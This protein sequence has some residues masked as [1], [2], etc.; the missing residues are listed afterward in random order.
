MIRI[1]SRLFAAIL[2][3]TF[4]VGAFAADAADSAAAPAGTEAT[5]TGD[6]VNVRGQASLTGEVITQINKGEKVVILAEIADA[7]AKKG[8]PAAW[9]KILLPT[10]TP[11]WIHAEF[12]DEATKTVKPRK[13]NVRSGP[14]ERF[15][16]IGTLTKGEVVKELRRVDSWVEIEPPAGT[17]GYVAAGF[18]KKVAPADAVP[19]VV[20]ETKPMETNA[21]TTAA[22]PVPA[23][24]NTP[25]TGTN[26]PV[27][28]SETVAL[29]NAPALAVATTNAPV[30][31]GD[32]AA[33]PDPVPSPV[34]VPAG[35]KP[36][37][38][39]PLQPRIVIRDGWVRRTL[40]IQAPTAYGLENS[41]NGRLMNYLM[42]T[43]DALNLRDLR[44]F[45]VTVKGEEYIDKRW[46]N[47]PIIKIHTIEFAP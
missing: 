42:S 10:N 37:E 3:V 47:T 2:G 46:P 28:A 31:L 13:L 26:A 34:V 14:G 25:T 32:P 41:V 35:E 1:S 23:T 40:S 5:V 6:R 21:V 22:V 7:K 9:A 11:V 38:D 29:T 45:Q 12:I 39:L 15:S 19:V 16:S 36:P 20:A 44:G 33:Q 4:A 43:N 30:I 24:T 27:V 8:A 18:L 17:F